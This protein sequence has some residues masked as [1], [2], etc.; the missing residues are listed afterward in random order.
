MDFDLSYEQKMMLDVTRK[1]VERELIPLEGEMI[2]AEFPPHQWQAFL[3]TTVAG[4][5]PADVV[6]DP[7]HLVVTCAGADDAYELRVWLHDRI[8]CEILSQFSCNMR[9]CWVAL[10]KG[11]R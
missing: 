2:E 7:A 4:D 11:V 8:P 10:S 9:R 6:C 1:F 5:S 3:R